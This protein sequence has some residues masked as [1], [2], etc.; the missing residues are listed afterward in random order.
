LLGSLRCIESVCAV[1][2]GA[3]V[4]AGPLRPK[5]GVPLKVKS[6]SSQTGQLPRASLAGVGQRCDMGK[7]LVAAKARSSRPPRTPTEWEPKKLPTTPA[8]CLP[9]SPRCGGRWGRT[10]STLRIKRTQ[11][12]WTAKKNKALVA[13]ARRA[14]AEAS[15]SLPVRW[16]HVKGHSGNEWND[17]ADELAKEGAGQCTATTT[18]RA[19]SAEGQ[20][21][22]VSAGGGWSAPRR[23]CRVLGALGG[24]AA[25]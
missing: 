17:R 7:R 22:T 18:P 3:R 15:R 19:Q 11:G 8:R 23:C 9:L 21:H 6:K 2:S 14:L 13:E 16:Q 1:R 5:T 25:D 10:Q 4:G 24:L 20:W 12:K